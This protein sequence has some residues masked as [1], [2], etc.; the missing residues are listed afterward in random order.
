KRARSTDDA[1][2]GFPNVRQELLP[3]A[4]LHLVL[5][6]NP[7]HTVDG[8]LLSDAPGLGNV[9][10]VK[11]FDRKKTVDAVGGGQVADV[12]LVA[13]DGSVAPKLEPVVEKSKSDSQVGLV[14]SGQVEIEVEIAQAAVEQVI[15]LA[16]QQL[17]D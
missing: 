1:L 6:A 17:P 11:N 2:D 14:K 9:L 15:D 7:V 16:R 5:Q 3:T 12:A 10:A 13:H 8:P 4:E